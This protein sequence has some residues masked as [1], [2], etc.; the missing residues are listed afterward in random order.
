MPGETAWRDEI[1]TEREALAECE[2]ANRTCR[3]G[4]EVYAKHR[5]GNW[6]GPY[7]GRLL[8]PED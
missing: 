6:T 5:N 3:P 2:L 7:T 4:H 1:S 8:D